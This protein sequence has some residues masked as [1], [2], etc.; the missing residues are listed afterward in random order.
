M[1]IICLDIGGTKI[2]G[3]LFNESG[4]ILYQYK[5]KSE[6]QHGFDHFIGQVHMVIDN[7]IANNE[8]DLQGIGIGFPGVIDRGGHIVYA[9]NLP[10][11]DFD[12][13]K[14]MQ[15]R[16]KTKVVVG[17]DVNLGTFGEYKELGIKD[18]HVIG[19]FPGTGFGGGIIVNGKPYIGNGFAGEIGH[20]V[21]N[22]DGVK[23][24]CGNKGCLEAYASKNGIGSYLKKE[25]KK[26]RKTG[27]KSDVK[28]GVLKSSKLYKAYKEKDALVVEAIDQF[29]RYFGI[30]L[31]NILNIFNPDVV[32]VGGGIVD[33]FGPK[34]LKKVKKVAKKYALP[35]VYDKTSIEISKL[36][37][38]AVIYGAYHLL[39]ISIGGSL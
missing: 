9:P 27:L 39:K 25:I 14:H 2:L 30:G 3:A 38:D 37:D 24:S 11:E 21:V 12:M 26:G 22:I 35:G 8:D 31:A 17:N 32:I 28:R 19:L 18:E 16:Y 20:M 10:V 13:I 34:L 7:L 29:Q 33:A 1:S 23:C 4:D 36:A 15:E 5:T 6:G